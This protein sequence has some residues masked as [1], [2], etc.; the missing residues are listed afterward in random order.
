MKTL[1]LSLILVLSVSVINAQTI[2]DK[3]FYCVQVLSTENPHLL[4]MEHV[5]FLPDTAMVEHVMIK[6]KSMYRIMFI[7]TDPTERDIYHTS[8]I[9]I[10]PDALRCTRKE[11]D[12]KQ[13]YP[14]FTNNN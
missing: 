6:G 7:Y 11:V 10:Y 5:N 14:L 8:W 2:E 12:V 3:T 13:M 4:T 9:K 1:I